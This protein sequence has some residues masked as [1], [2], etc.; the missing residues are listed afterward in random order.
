MKQNQELA[1]ALREAARRIEARE[2]RYSWGALHSCNCGVLAQVIVGCDEAELGLQLYGPE[3]A[4]VGFFYGCWDSVDR[5][6][7]CPL[8]G[9]PM[10]TVLRALGDAGMTAKDLADLEDLKG[11]QVIASLGEC[12]DRE[13]PSDVIRYMRAWAD[14]LDAPEQTIEMKPEKAAA[15]EVPS[16]AS[17]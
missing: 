8:T 11:E 3:H 15:L 6:C 9:L 5:K 1:A 10:G 13:D 14:L 7:T 12:V 4:Q 16:P 2:V 17:R